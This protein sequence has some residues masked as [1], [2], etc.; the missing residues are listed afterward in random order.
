MKKGAKT[1]AIH[2]VANIL[3]WFMPLNIMAQIFTSAEVPDSIWH[4]MQGHSYPKG[5]T[6]AR[7]QLRYLRLSYCDF[8]GN[9]H[10]GQMVCNHLIADDL[11]YIFSK[12]Y[13]ARYPIASIKLIDTYDAND[14]LSMAANN[15]SS[16]CYRMVHGSKTLS[17]HSRGMAVDVNPLYNPC[18]YVRS[19]KVLPTEGKPYAYQ[20]TTRKDIPGRIDTTD[21]CYRLFTQRGFRWGGTWRSLKD[22]QHF[23]K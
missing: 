8:D 1:K 10:I 13:E 11:L 23:E 14:N 20:R 16:F 12:L 5:C 15:T 9:E 4:R 2:Y 7:S 21:L 22:Y 17:K 3:I 19:G 6:I 18:V